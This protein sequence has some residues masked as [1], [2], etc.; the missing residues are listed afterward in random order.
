[1]VIFLDEIQIR[2]MWPI[3]LGLQKA[4]VDI[5][6]RLVTQLDLGFAQIPL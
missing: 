4:G 5:A 2:V 1:M 6:W 3:K